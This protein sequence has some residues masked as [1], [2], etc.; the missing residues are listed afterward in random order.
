MHVCTISILLYPEKN[1]KIVFWY[2]K[3]HIIYKKYTLLAAIKS[4]Q[5]Q[6][7]HKHYHL[8][9]LDYNRLLLLRFLSSK[10]SIITL[11]LYSPLS[12]FSPLNWSSRFDDIFTTPRSLNLADIRRSQV[13]VHNIAHTLPQTIKTN[14]LNA[15]KLKPMFVFKNSLLL[16]FFLCCCCCTCFNSFK[17]ASNDP[18][19]KTEHEFEGNDEAV[20]ETDKPWPPFVVGAFGKGH[21]ESDLKISSVSDVL[22]NEIESLIVFESLLF[23]SVDIF[24]LLGDLNDI[25]RNLLLPSLFVCQQLYIYDEEPQQQLCI[26]ELI[27]TNSKQFI[28]SVTSHLKIKTVT[29]LKKG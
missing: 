9:V 20:D 4:K 17:V 26:T 14:K 19:L 18:L 21:L 1:C 22:F 2:F 28:H 6:P 11:F 23:C 12:T 13:E 5:S 24:L 10:P 3:N 29:L 27:I 7:R 25:D 16:T 15:I 8:S